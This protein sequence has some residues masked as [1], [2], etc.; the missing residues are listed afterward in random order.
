M[1]DIR[2][3]QMVEL[4]ILKEFIRICENHNLR[5]FAIGGTVLGAVRHNGFIPWDDDVDVS[6]PRE[7][8]DKFQELIASGV[9]DNTYEVETMY[10][11]E[12]HIAP[13]MKFVDTSVTMVFT[14]A[15]IE[16]KTNAFIDIFPLDGLPSN[17]IIRF[18]HVRRFLIQL[19][20]FL[21][22]T[23]D[24][25][26]RQDNKNR[27]LP[28]RLAMWACNTFNVQ[29]FFNKRK[30][31]RRGDKI[32]TKYSFGKTSFCS[33]QLWGHYK[34]RAIFPT[35]WLG[36]GTTLQF[37]DIE[38]NAPEHYPKYLQQ[39]YGANYMELPP[40]NKRETHASSVIFHEGN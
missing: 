26:V 33:P 32:L 8:Y 15:K 27:S 1:E 18:F 23:F 29:K 9:T 5:Y 4:S 34:T 40:E 36:A 31:V 37:E 17:K 3:L 20:L 16:Y 11:H 10:T 19:Y 22:S 38:I 14:R 21:F 39:L 24:T 13:A 2:K 30:I 35:E 28:V 12:N 6:M 7:D 25:S